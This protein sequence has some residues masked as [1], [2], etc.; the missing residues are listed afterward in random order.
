MTNPNVEHILLHTL[1]GQTG[2]G[3]TSHLS[4]L[5]INVK[6]LLQKIQFLHAEECNVQIMDFLHFL[7]FLRHFRTAA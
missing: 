5:I 2:L 1:F 3:K 4:V 6:N 7:L